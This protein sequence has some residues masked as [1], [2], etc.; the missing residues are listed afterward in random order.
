MERDSRRHFKRHMIYGQ[1][2]ASQLGLNIYYYVYL[3]PPPTN[4]I[5]L[6]YFLQ[7][8]KKS[9]CRDFNFARFLF[10]SLSLVPR[11]AAKLRTR[12]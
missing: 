3:L 5:G 9:L 2:Q 7:R 11:F 8:V 4:F 1:C 6:Y 10:S 12:A